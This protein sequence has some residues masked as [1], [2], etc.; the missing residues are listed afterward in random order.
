MVVALLYNNNFIY[1]IINYNKR[2]CLENIIIW[3][4]LNVEWLFSGLGVSIVGIFFISIIGIIKFS[5]KK[6]DTE[7]IPSSTNQT[8]SINTTISPTINI[9]GN[10]YK[11][12]EN[13]EVETKLLDETFNLEEAKN[14]TKILFIDDDT[15][16][17]VI[18]ILKKSGWINT[19]IIKD[20]S[21]LDSHDVKETD[22]FF[23]DIQGVGLKL[24]FQDE[25]LGLADALKTRYPKKKVVIYSAENRGKIFHD[26]LKKADDSLQKNAEPFQFQT[27]IEEL[28]KK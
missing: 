1:I 4:K 10:D 28:L 21:N 19:K 17:K 12:R 6:E 23:V 15:K 2:I 26:A 20:I 18:N 3:L 27:T 16:F 24:N 13:K 14:N 8:G 11:N 9:N 5:L 7:L 25:G 22:I